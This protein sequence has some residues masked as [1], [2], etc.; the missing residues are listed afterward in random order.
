M[1]LE[2]RWNFGLTELN[3]ITPDFETEGFHTY[4]WCSTSP[5]PPIL[6]DHR[7]LASYPLHISPRDFAVHL[8]KTPLD[9]FNLWLLLLI[10]ERTIAWFTFTLRK[11]RIK[12][13]TFNSYKNG[14]VEEVN[15]SG[16]CEILQLR[17]QEWCCWVLQGCSWVWVTGYLHNLE[18]VK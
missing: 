12:P 14:R 8:L 17:N 13:E 2:F 1:I 16:K 10:Q 11:Q 3:S 4:L 15:T 6:S 5:I 7:T 18:T 9:R